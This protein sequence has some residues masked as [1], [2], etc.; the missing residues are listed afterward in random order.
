MC[1]IPASNSN[2]DIIAKYALTFNGYY[3]VNGG[4]KE[5]DLLWDKV[6]MDIENSSINDLR[7][8]LFLLQMAGRFCG[9]EGSSYDIET[10]NFIIDMIRKKIDV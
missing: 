8:C 9:D 10:A 6:M 4:P 5:L 1:N 2:W 3:Y 7:A